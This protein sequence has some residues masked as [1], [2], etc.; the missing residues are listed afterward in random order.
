METKSLTSYTLRLFTIH[1]SQLMLSLTKRR[2]AYRKI[3]CYIA[4]SFLFLRIQAAGGVK[5]TSG[6][7]SIIKHGAAGSALCFDVK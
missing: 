1:D 3:H 4:G 6:K 7:T 5:K 2:E